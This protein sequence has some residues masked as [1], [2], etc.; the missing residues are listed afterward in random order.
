M[1]PD[2]LKFCPGLYVVYAA[3]VVNEISPMIILV[4]VVLRTGGD[5]VVVQLP[6]RVPIA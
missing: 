6:P 4:Y 5:V 3:G 2:V 1:V